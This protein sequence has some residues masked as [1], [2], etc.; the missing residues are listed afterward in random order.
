MWINT[1][2][3]ALEINFNQAGNSR[4]ARNMRPSIQTVG[5][6]VALQHALTP[7]PLQPTPPHP[8][9]DRRTI[10]SSS[11]MHHRCTSPT[12][13]SLCLP[14]TTNALKTSKNDALCRDT[15]ETWGGMLEVP[16]PSLTIMS[17]VLHEKLK[18]TQF[19]K[20]FFK[21]YGIRGLSNIITGNIQYINIRNVWTL[22]FNIY[23]LNCI[24]KENKGKGKIHPVGRVA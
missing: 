11:N 21:F 22:L 10:N 8:V 15:S 2:V 3:Y 7:S 18:V 14:S 1:H 19:V 6:Q 4:N 24:I 17:T 13:S 9:L 23:Y 20:K 12:C 5:T 16:S